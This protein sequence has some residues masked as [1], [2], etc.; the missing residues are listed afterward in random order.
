MPNTLKTENILLNIGNT[1]KRVVIAGAL[2][3][4]NKNIQK[5]VYSNHKPIHKVSKHNSIKQYLYDI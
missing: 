2:N 1:T 5:F 4:P 3:I